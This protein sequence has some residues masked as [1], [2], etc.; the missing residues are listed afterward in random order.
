MSF[1]S[2]TFIFAL[3]V[4]SYSCESDAIEEPALFSPEEFEISVWAES[5]MF[6]NPTNMDVDAKGRIWVTEAVNYRNYNN[7]SN[8]FLHHAQGDRVMILE[9]TDQDGVADS[10]R[11][12]VQDPDLV[13]PLGIAVF[14]KRVF[15]SCAPHLL[16]YTDEDG[17]D[18]PD[19]KEIFL[20]GFGGLDHDHSLHSILAGPDGK[21][22]FNTG[23]AG[24][25]QVTDKSGWTLRSGSLYTGGSPY[26]TTNSGGQISD[27]GKVYVGGLALKI[28]PD[29]TGLEV[30]AHNFRNSYEVFVDSRGDLWQND[31]DD[32]VVTCRVS[33]IPE[34]GNAGYFSSDGT[35]TWQADQRPGQDIFSAHWHQDDPGVMPAGDKTGAGSP[36]G[37]MRYEGDAFGQQFRGTLL[38]ADAGRNSIFSYQP[39]VFKSG[40]ELGSRTILFS[41]VKE[42][43]EGY[44]WNDTSFHSQKA[45]WFRPSDLVTGTDGAIYIADWY[46]PVVGGH[47]IKDSAAMGKIYRI[48][49]KDKKLSTPTL[50]YDSDQ[51]LVEVLKNPAVN[52]RLKAFEALK[53]KGDTAIPL[54]EPL[55]SDENP[56]IKSRA[57]YLLAQLGEQGKQKTLKLLDSED[58]MT[59]LEA[60]RAIKANGNPSLLPSDQLLEDPSALVRRTYAAMLWDRDW[61][62][63]K[64]AFELLLKDFDPTDSWYLDALGKMAAGHEQEAFAISQKTFPLTDK[65]EWSKELE[66]L[67]WRIPSKEAIP[68]LKKRLENE[69]LDTK[70]Q[71]YVLTSLAFIPEKSAAETMYSFSNHPDSSL[72]EMANYWLSF[73]QGNDWKD[74]L[75]WGKIGVDPEKTRKLAEMKAKRSLLLE[76]KMALNNRKNQAKAMAKDPLGGQMLM[77]MLVSN[78]LPADLIETVKETIPSNPNLGVRVQAG[79]YFGSKANGENYAID[80]LK[81]LNS[82]VLRG[83][84]AFKSFCTTCHSVNGEGKDIG[85]DLSQIKTKYDQTTLLDAIINPNGG[86]VFGY[87]PWLVKLKS[88]ESYYGFIQGET[89][90]TLIIKDL[91]GKRITLS[92]SEID[93]KKQE[94]YSIMPDPASLGMKAQ[95]LADISTYLLNLR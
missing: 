12:F 88:G 50:D 1:K 57:I 71:D 14:G 29:G 46:D 11:V 77:E 87:E 84:A 85:P 62:V 36:T 86:I 37:M 16:V 5:P 63:R 56:F 76:E 8:S 23:N 49:P 82:D 22:Y 7:D 31:N 17:D 93:Q 58:E 30:L 39:Q 91:S 41:S 19:K 51:G 52:V 60:L 33:W 89:K 64:K 20:T 67:A 26:N 25:H 9:D 72:A 32:Q 55:L 27:D 40:Y 68:A 6:F 44:V 53:A 28:N 83:E 92:L 73:R 78:S 38:S 94:A 79:N 34:K 48:V 80:H 81:S 3:S 18:V 59:R 42:D 47:Q 75:D 65:G 66:A 70:K 24:P 13:S 95:E 10:S 74:F 69:K 35:R 90:E 21:L 61:E 4:L 15:I 43:D 54:I 2:I 45:K